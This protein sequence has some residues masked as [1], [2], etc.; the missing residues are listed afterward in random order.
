M[1]WIC[2]KLTFQPWN[3]SKSF[4]LFCGWGGE[5]WGDGDLFSTLQPLSYRCNIARLALYHC[6][7]DKCSDEHNSLIPIVQIFETR[8]RH[9][10]STES[11]HHFLYIPNVIGKIFSL[12][13]LLLC[14]TDSSM[15]VSL[16]SKTITFFKPL[17]IFIYSPYPQNLNFI[18]TFLHMRPYSS[19]TLYLE[20]QSSL[21][22]I[23]I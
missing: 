18:P 9:V 19:L 5:W 16:N 8:I 2:S 3:R 22:L 13:E 14:G 7:H 17:S 4:T 12:P 20:R 6:L 1:S 15:D 11:N 10:T 23:E 21:V